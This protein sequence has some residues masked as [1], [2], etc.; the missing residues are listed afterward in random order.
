MGL[1]K[2]FTREMKQ[3]GFGTILQVA[4]NGAYHPS[5]GYAVY[6]AT[7]SFGPSFGE[8]LNNKLK[9][10]PVSVTVISPFPTRTEFHDVT[11]RGRDNLYIKLVTMKSEQVARL[12]IRAMLQGKHSMVPGLINALGA[13]LAQRMP[14]GWALTAAARMMGVQ[15]GGFVDDR[16][17]AC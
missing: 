17:W 9:D 4:S 14:R 10:S 13:W 7:K 6:G 12:G 8:A 2:L 15:P 5:P 16:G 3:R 1:T 11:G